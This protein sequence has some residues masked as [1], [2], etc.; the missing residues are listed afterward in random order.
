M[1]NDPSITGSFSGYRCIQ[2]KAREKNLGE[3]TATR[4]RHILEGNRSYTFHGLVPPLS[5]ELRLCPGE[6]NLSKHNQTR[7]N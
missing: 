4:A 6:R 1:Y 3:V 5:V 7:Q 2:Q